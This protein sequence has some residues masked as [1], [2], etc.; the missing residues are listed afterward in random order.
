MKKQLGI[1]LIMVLLAGLAGAAWGQDSLN[2]RKAG[3][4]MTEWMSPMMWS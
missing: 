4:W 2:V 1:I 3:L